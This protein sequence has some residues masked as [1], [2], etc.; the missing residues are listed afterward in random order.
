MTTLNKQ[1]VAVT[2][3]SGF[4]G[5]RVVERFVLNRSHR[6]RGLARGYGRLARMSVLPQDELEFRLG[7]LDDPDALVDALSGV[8]TVVHTAF[9]SSGDVTQRW[10]AT[11]EGTRAVLR[12]ARDAGVR[13]VVHLSTVDV[14]APGAAVLTEAC[15]PLPRDEDDQEYEQQKLVAERIALEFA[16]DLEVVVL[17]PGIVYGPWGK[18]WT[19]DVLDRLANDDSALPSGPAHGRCNAVH[20]DDVVDAVRAAVNGT[21]STG[22]RYLVAAPSIGWNEFFDGFRSVLGM[23]PVPAERS[24]VATLPD[25]ERDLYSAQTEIDSRAA[26]TELG[27]CPQIGWQAGLESV[28]AWARWAGRIAERAT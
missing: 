4:I 10:A 15:A 11:V 3:A 21:V 6:V 27:F 14:Y 5:G 18:S 16:D 26:A 28:R 13:R 2:G 24:A 17:Q 25:W 22:S 9:G 8:D 20:V 23:P 19:E 1:V 7:P 12:S